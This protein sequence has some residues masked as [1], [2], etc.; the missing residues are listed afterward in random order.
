MVTPRSLSTDLNV[1]T[2]LQNLLIKI[3]EYLLKNFIAWG[4]N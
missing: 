2:T 1:R 4:M 3:Y